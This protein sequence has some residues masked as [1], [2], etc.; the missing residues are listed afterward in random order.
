MEPAMAEL[1][2]VRVPEYPNTVL[3]VSEGHVANYKGF[4]ARCET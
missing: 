3:K 4:P 1:V 2:A